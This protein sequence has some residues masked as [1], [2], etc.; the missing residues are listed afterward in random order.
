MWVCVCARDRMLMVA[1]RC[2]R[3]CFTQVDILSGLSKKTH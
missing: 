1:M 2:L 3:Q